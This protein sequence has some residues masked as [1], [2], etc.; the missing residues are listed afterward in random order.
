MANTLDNANPVIYEQTEARQITADEENNDI[1]DEIDTREIFGIL[2]PLQR[3]GAT[4]Q[5]YP[6]DLF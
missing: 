5:F 6:Q 2:F 4:L 3:M 1:V